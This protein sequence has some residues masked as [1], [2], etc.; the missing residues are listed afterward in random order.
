MVSRR[1]NAS[2]SG[3]HSAT[4]PRFIFVKG[5]VAL[6]IQVLIRLIGAFGELG[7]A[8]I[9]RLFGLKDRTHV[10]ERYVNPSLEEGWIEMTIAD[11][12]NSRLQKYRLTAMGEAYLQANPSG[13]VPS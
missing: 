13:T 8:D 11:K 7:S 10:R 5:E 12:P 2:S 9:R 1:H 4:F 3:L 6:A